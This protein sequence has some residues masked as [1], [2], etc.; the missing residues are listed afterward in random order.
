MKSSTD[1]LVTEE[2]SVTQIVAVEEAVDVRFTRADE[3]YDDNGPVIEALYNRVRERVFL[4][5]RDELPFLFKFKRLIDA[6]PRDPKTHRLL[7]PFHGCYSWSEICLECLHRDPRTIRYAFEDKD[8]EAEK[9][10][11]K[12]ARQH[13][14]NVAANAAALA[15]HSAPNATEIVRDGAEFFP[16]P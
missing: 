5:I 10:I 9:A 15:V 6:R 3:Y 11:K 16:P 8:T 4:K 1:K 2:T 14:K 13:A 12:A 7:T